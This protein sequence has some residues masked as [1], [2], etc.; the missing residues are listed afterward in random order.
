[1]YYFSG[2]PLLCGGWCLIKYI[3]EARDGVVNVDAGEK[4]LTLSESLLSKLASGSG[5]TVMLYNVTTGETISFEEGIIGGYN[6]LAINSSTLDPGTWKLG[7]FAVHSTDSKISVQA[8][9]DD[10]RFPNF[11]PPE[12]IS[13]T[14]RLTS[15]EIAALGINPSD[16]SFNLINTKA[17]YKPPSVQV[18]SIQLSDKVLNVDAGEKLL[19]L[20]FSVTDD[21]S[22][23]DFIEITFRND[24]AQAEKNLYYSPETGWDRADFSMLSDFSWAAPGTWYPVRI[25]AEDTSGNII[26]YYNDGFDD[27]YDA[28]TLL[29]AGININSI[30]FSVINKI[31]DT[32]KPV[33]SFSSPQLADYIINVDQ[34]ENSLVVNGAV[35]DTGS[36]FQYLDISWRNVVT[37]ARFN[38]R[39]DSVSIDSTGKFTIQQDTS[40][41]SAGDWVVDYLNI[42]DKAENTLK[43]FIFD[44]KSKTEKQKLLS[45][46]IDIDRLAFKVINSKDIDSNSDLSRPIFTISAGEISDGILDAAIGEKA[47]TLQGMV[48]DDKSGFS[49]LNIKFVNQSTSTTRSFWINPSDL[50]DQGGFHKIIDFSWAANGTWIIESFYSRDNAGNELNYYRSTHNGS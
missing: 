3:F 46:G 16:F 17:D 31:A 7:I 39:T 38:I 4:V 50:D 11:T 26:N 48:S 44:F 43:Y 19:R 29:S 20:D 2:L 12:E 45:A 41:L 5:Y 40:R 21:K 42:S 14:K 1:L 8:Y 27:Q 25:Y 30:T 32:V 9:W 49:Y 35:V 47:L 36:G 28:S 22:K 6:K 24:A 33:V 15:T 10:A 23:L 37:D 18:S 13:I 34:G